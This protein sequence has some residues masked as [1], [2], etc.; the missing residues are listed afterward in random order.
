MFTRPILA[1]AAAIVALTTACGSDAA[2]DDSLRAR[3]ILA[4]ADAG[5][6][7]PGTDGFDASVD[8]LVET[9]TVDD[10]VSELVAAADSVRE[11]IA[12]TCPEIL[13]GR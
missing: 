11:Q 7:E 4:V 9:C 5:H 6:Y 12:A 1:I 3:A 13:E 8:I 10:V 2:T